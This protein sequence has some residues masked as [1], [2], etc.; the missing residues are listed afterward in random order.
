MGSGVLPAYDSSTASPAAALAAPQRDASASL[1]TE[2]DDPDPDLPP[3]TNEANFDKGAY[4]R[5]RS[6]HVNILRGAVP[7]QPFDATA[8]LRALQQLSD[9]R[10]RSGT[11]SALISQS[12]WTSLGPA[13]IP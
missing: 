8:R 11:V 4:L 13:P 7:G 9:Q 12:T 1:L 5:A 3:F 2:D 6:D 10:A